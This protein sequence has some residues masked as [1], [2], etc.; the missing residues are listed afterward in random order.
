MVC[1]DAGNGPVA[2]GMVIA[3]PVWGELGDGRPVVMQG[4]DSG[5]VGAADGLWVALLGVARGDAI[6]EGTAEVEGS[7]GVVGGN[8][9]G[10][11][12]GTGGTGIDGG[13]WSSW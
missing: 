9:K 5:A 10:V 12:V 1:Q 2:D 6:A 8:G 4:P 3:V 7:G 13:V 11:G